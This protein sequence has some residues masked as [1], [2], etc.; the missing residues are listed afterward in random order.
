[1]FRLSLITFLLIT[2]FA[3]SQTLMTNEEAAVLA[4]Q[5]G[6]Q[7]VNYELKSQYNGLN[8]TEATIIDKLKNKGIITYQVVNPTG[9][10]I[11]VDIT[12]TGK[13]YIAGFKEEN[14]VGYIYMAVALVETDKVNEVRLHQT[15]NNAQVIDYQLKVLDVSPVGE[16]LGTFKRFQTFSHKVD[17]EPTSNGWQK[18]ISDEND[19]RIT[20][21]NLS[22]YGKTAVYSYQNYLKNQ[23]FLTDL[24]NI[25]Q[26]KWDRS[27]SKEKKREH[28]IFNADG[29]FEHYVAKK[30]KTT[31]GKY[32]FGTRLVSSRSLILIPRE[33]RDKT[34][35]I[36][37]SGNN[38]TIN[39][40]V[41]IKEG[42]GITR[43]SAAVSNENANAER[44]A[45][46]LNR[47]KKLY[48]TYMTGFWKSS[49]GKVTM[50]FLEDNKLTF[51]EKKNE[52]SNAT[53]EYIIEEGELFLI[54]LDQDL[55]EVYKKKAS[56]IRGESMRLGSTTFNKL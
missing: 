18:A 41:F 39:R 33:G 29:S 21:N 14:G 13:K 7:T 17:Y 6:Y 10:Q 56:V 19:L 3:S 16:S 27:T 22:Q 54:I 25:I 26:G 2:S 55:N 52:Y 45:N 24:P 32:K 34:V 48:T 5:Y 30:D 31:K 42:S 36:G 38:I 44:K 1:M 40:T 37:R 4:K 12:A 43:G 15:K 8:K 46:M 49:N 50:D 23:E 53:F 28:Y 51:K 20:S 9:P 47:K 35:S 11:K